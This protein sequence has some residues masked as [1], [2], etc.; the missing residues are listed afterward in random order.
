VSV[1]AGTET[2]LETIE[3]LDF[4][5]DRACE[6][7]D[8]P[9]RPPAAWWGIPSCGCGNVKATCAGCKD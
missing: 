6:L 7:T 1:P 9:D 5:A 2:V 8:C 4:D 3:H